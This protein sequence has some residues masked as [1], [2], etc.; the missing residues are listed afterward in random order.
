MK[1]TFK[2]VF[3]ELDDELMA[4]DMQEN[5]PVDIDV[6]K[7][8]SEVFMR[9]NDEDKPKKKFSKK[10]IVI[11]AAAVI[12]V[13]GTVGA[14]ATGSVQ[15]IFRGY[16]KG[17]KV[18]DLGLYDGGDV[19]VQSDD[20]DVKLLGVMSDGEIAHS[21]I[22]VTKK[23]GGD[24]IKDG[25]IPTGK[26]P[27]F[28]GVNRT[29]GESNTYEIFYN[30]GEKSDSE[31][32]LVRSRCRLSEDRKTL[33]IYSDYARTARSERD[34]TDFRIT[35]NN[36]SIEVY[37]LDK[38]LYTEVLPEVQS[39][40]KMTEEQIAMENTYIHRGSICIRYWPEICN[41]FDSERDYSVS[42]PE[43]IPVYV[44]NVIRAENGS[45]NEV[46]SDEYSHFLDRGVKL[47]FLIR[48]DEWDKVMV[49]GDMLP[50]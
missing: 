42:Y 37:K 39:D 48:D 49:K 25:Y 9:I 30:N 47:L 21:A 46:L 38:V 2:T 14:F 35:Y 23:D 8:K 16:F 12:L 1:T 26:L 5:T 15:S 19:Q 50:D 41:S 43:S 4:L 36:N 45:F 27:S 33:S 24:I 28:A 17:D 32:A 34:L 20:F 13:G 18:N 29:D 6:D 31:G 3:T 10:I 40:D 44:D 22:E 11:L 7:I